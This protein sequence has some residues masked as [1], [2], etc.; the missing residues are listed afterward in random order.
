MA[1]TVVATRGSMEEAAEKSFRSKKRIVV[2]CQQV[3]S[4]RRDKNAHQE[5]E[6]VDARVRTTRR[7]PRRIQP[8]E[9]PSRRSGVWGSPYDVDRN[10]DRVRLEKSSCADPFRRDG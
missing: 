6:Q 2:S 3:L 7:T 10:R 9:S 5:E 8:S 4:C 1:T